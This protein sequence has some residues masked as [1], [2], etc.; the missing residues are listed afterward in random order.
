MTA[1]PWDIMQST[2]VETPWGDYMV[3]TNREG[4]T[5]AFGPDGEQVDFGYEDRH[6]LAVDFMRRS[7]A[8]RE[9]QTYVYHNL[10]F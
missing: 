6:Y 3:S 7:F 5:V 1:R 9:G 4:S 8:A 10:P 2:I